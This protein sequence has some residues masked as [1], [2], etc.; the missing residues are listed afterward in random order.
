MNRTQHF[1]VKGATGSPCREKVRLVE[2]YHAATKA[3]CLAVSE[4]HEKIGTTAR[5]VYLA[6]RDNVERAS[7]DASR[8]RDRMEHHV[9][10]HRC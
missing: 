7:Q 8:A 9:R 4:W 10:E 3:Y 6:M 2:E 5:S 1:V